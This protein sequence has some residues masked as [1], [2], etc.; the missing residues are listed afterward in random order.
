MNTTSL[1][2]KTANAT[3][4]P[5]RREKGFREEL[6]RQA[7]ANK[8]GPYRRKPRRGEVALQD[9]PEKYLVSSGMERVLNKLQTGYLFT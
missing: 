2:I 4:F 3:E 5:S 7:R 6:R 9:K 8:R 1:K